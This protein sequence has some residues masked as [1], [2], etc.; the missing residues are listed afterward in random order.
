SVLGLSVIVLDKLVAQD[1]PDIITII[2]R[3]I[4]EAMSLKIAK[5]QATSSRVLF[6][7]PLQFKYVR[8]R[9]DSNGKR[10]EDPGEYNTTEV[11]VTAKIK[12]ME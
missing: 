1:N 9:F 4:T 7:D 11:F 10:L 3:Q 8:G 5:L 2:V 12:E 6:V